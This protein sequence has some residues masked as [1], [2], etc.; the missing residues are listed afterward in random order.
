VID[1]GELKT[2]GQE[3]EDRIAV[4]FRPPAARYAAWEEAAGDKP[5]S[6]WL[7]ELADKAAKWKR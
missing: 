4:M 3:G 1:I 2:R 6:V 5:V 7:G